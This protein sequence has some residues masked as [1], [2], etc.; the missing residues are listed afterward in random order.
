M[1][2][3]TTDYIA[4]STERIAELTNVL[5]ERSCIH[6]KTLARD[7]WINFWLNSTSQS[8]TYS[9]LDFLN[10]VWEEQSFRPFDDVTSSV[11]FLIQNPGKGLLVRLSTTV[12][13]A[14]TVTF[15]AKNNKIFH[16]RF[17]L[18][19]KAY[20]EDGK[21]RSFLNIDELSQWFLKNRVGIHL[22]SVSEYLSE[23]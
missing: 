12:P 15:R 3:R 19:D 9:R 18:N 5:F 10:R 17:L 13:G 23:F 11:N 2:A 6:R 21:G 22:Y 14:I 1:V 8:K 16:E 4:L 20:L 7:K